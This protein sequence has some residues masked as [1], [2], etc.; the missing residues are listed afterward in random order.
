MGISQRIFGVFL[1]VV[2]TAACAP[3]GHQATET[4]VSSGSAIIGGLAV[5]E[6]DPIS[7]STVQ[8]LNFKVVRDKNDHVTAI[9]GLSTC[10]G[11]ILAQDVILTAGHCSSQDPRNL[12][13]LFSNQVPDFKEFM[14]TAAQNPQVRRV[15][16]GVT[17]PNWQHLAGDTDQNWGDLSLLKFSGGLPSGYVPA[18]LLPANAVESINESITLAGFG[19]TDGVKKTQ[20]TELLQVTVQ[21]ADPKFS[22]TEMLISNTN[23]TGACHGDSGGPAY[24]S[25]QGQNYLAGVTSRADIKSDPKAV[26]VGKTIYTKVQPYLPWISSEIQKLEASNTYGLVIAEPTQN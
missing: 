12:I 13:L 14:K 22:D 2:F 20:A 19:E 1:G 18:T 10:T 26:C 15:N 11:T 7:H 8:L 16:A 9:T 23:G 25:S 6:Q 5:S 21:I 17:A 3:Q 4:A 24:I